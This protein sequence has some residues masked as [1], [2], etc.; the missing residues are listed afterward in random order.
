MELNI[1]FDSIRMLTFGETKV[2]KGEFY[3]AKKQTKI[4]YVNVNNSKYLIGYLDAVVRPFVLIL[5]KMK[6]IC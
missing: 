3:V 6:R 2:A 5:T 4:W 1:F